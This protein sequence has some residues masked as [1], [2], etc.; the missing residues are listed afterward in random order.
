MKMYNVVHFAA[1]VI[2]KQCV[3][4]LYVVS[5]LK[6]IAISIKTCIAKMFVHYLSKDTIKQYRAGVL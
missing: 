3:E 1:K 4:Y 2:L 5:I 6:S